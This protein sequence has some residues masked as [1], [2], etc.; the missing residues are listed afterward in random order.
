MK[1]IFTKNNQPLSVFIRWGLKE[2]VSHFAIV[3]DDTIVFHSNLLGCHITWF[4]H[5]KKSSSIVFQI[6]K[7]LSLEKEE[8]IYRSI[9]NKNYGKSYDFTA[10]LFFIW[11]SFLYRVF[12][13]PLP[14]INKLNSSNNILCTGLAAELPLDEFPELSTIKDTEMLSPY[15]LYLRLKNG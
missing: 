3:F 14:E 1:L 5:F 13:K 15:Q 10:F 4:D 7:K 8:H 9:I 12:N 11:R 2:P 6:E